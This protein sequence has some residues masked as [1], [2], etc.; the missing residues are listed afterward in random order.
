M[1]D[2]AKGF[3]SICTAFIQINPGFP[4]SNELKVWRI[5]F[6]DFISGIFN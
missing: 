4:G 5:S 1:A 6:A 3:I 2:L